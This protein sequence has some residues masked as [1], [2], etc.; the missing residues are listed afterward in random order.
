MRNNHLDR[1]YEDR[2]NLIE[3]LSYR[4]VASLFIKAKE[5]EMKRRLTPGEIFD[6]RDEIESEKLTIK[7]MREIIYNSPLTLD[8]LRNC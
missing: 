1:Y 4:D 5:R 6:I 3:S 7:G 8:E 2:D